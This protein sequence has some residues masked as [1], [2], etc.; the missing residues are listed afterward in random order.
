[1]PALEP[2]SPSL[3]LKP[4]KEG[5]WRQQQ[6]QGQWGHREES[7]PEFPLSGPA[8]AQEYRTLGLSL[9]VLSPYPGDSQGL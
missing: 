7:H 9:G 5:A 8:R 3:Q 6:R 2:E 4:P 1:M